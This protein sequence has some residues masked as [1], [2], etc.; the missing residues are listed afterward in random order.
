MFLEIQVLTRNLSS[1]EEPVKQGGPV[2]FVNPRLVRINADKPLKI[3]EISLERI[4]GSERVKRNYE[5]RRIAD[6]YEK[7]CLRTIMERD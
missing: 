1:V 3:F 7:T 5:I 6:A 2:L 4:C